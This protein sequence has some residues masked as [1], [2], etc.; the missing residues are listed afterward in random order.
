MGVPEG[1]F[2]KLILDI[3][4]RWNST[5]N[6]IERFI[7]LAPVLKNII[8]GNINAPDMTTTT[9]LEQLNKFASFYSH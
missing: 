1:K 5:F 9:E 7:K 3:K 2:K 6:M 8:F 4:T